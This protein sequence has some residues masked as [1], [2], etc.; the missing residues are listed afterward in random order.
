MRDT[1]SESC[2]DVNTLLNEHIHAVETRLKEL[3]LL[4][5]HLTELRRQCTIAATTDSCGILLALGEQG[6]RTH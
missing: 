4:K 1:H 3:T 6:S 5:Q 2:C